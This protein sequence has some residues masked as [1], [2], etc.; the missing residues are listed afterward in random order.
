M[1]LKD[2]ADKT[3]VKYLT[4][5]RWFKS[6]TLPVKAYQTESGTIIIEE[7]NETSESKM[8]VNQQNDAMSLFLK[9]TVEYSKNDSTVEDF[10]AY[11]LSNFTLKLNGSTESPKYSKNK[12]KPE[13]IQEHFKKYL[14]IKGEKPKPN[15]FVASEEMFNE[16]AAKSDNLTAQEMANE[17][18]SFTSQD[19]SV[20]IKSAAAQAA[21]VPEFQD[22]IKDLSSAITSPV[23][24]EG[25]YPNCAF[26]SIKMYDDQ[27]TGGVFNS[28]VDL[29]PQ[30]QNYTSS[31][32]HAIGSLSFGPGAT[33]FVSNFGS[34]GD[35][36]GEYSSYNSSVVSYISPFSLTKKEVSGAVKL[37]QTVDKPKRGRPRKNQ[38]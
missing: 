26:G 17:L 16:L 19:G 33:N 6:G 11:V 27:T 23:S 12:P 8:P 1:K 22:L 29:S 3:G 15:M 34:T 14:P 37:A 21:A 13:E 18:K 30:Q 2:W 32:E 38:L 28:N 24:V 5:Y 20:D 9:K 25:S 7:N 35:C 31:P 4:A 10:A 36:A